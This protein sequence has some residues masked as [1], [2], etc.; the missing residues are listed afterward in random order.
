MKFIPLHKPYFGIQ[1]IKNAV[2][3]IKSGKIA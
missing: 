3:V 1:E 2:R